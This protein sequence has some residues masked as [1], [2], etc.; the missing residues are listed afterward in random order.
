MRFLISRFDYLEKCMKKSA[1]FAALISLSALGFVSVSAQNA[2]GRI[3][4]IN[5][6]AFG[7]EKAGI[8]KYVAAVKQINAEVA[9]M[10]KEIETM[11]SKLSA[12]AKEIESVRSQT[13]SGTPINETTLRTKVD[14][15]EKL[16]LD[17]KR[18]QED[19]KVRLEKRQLA[20]LG[21]VM[22]EIGKSLQVFA[23][24]K[25]YALI[26]DIAK[27]EAGILAAIGD[28]KTVVTAEFIT[29]FNAR[30]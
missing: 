8:T 26:L 27:D 11:S 29:Y 3:V 5:S 19:G 1:L 6:F 10:Q 4:V 18:K 23:R 22:Q 7:D 12:L 14:E 30:P 9:P 21:P 25:G 24:E 28:E 17:I 2:P 13:I 20:L 15:A 16:Q